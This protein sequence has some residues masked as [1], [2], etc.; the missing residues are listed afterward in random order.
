MKSFRRL[1]LIPAAIAAQLALAGLAIPAAR[2]ADFSEPALLVAAPELTGLYAHTVVLALPAGSGTHIG[3]I[4]NRPTET[5]LAA[6]F[7][8]SAP[9]RRVTSPI[10]VGG[11]ELLD[12]LFALVR[13]PRPPAEGSRKVLP[14]LFVAFQASDVAEAISR[15]PDRSRFFA[16]LVSWDRGELEAESGDGAW[17]LLDPDVELVLEASVDTLWSRLVA[18]TQSVTVQRQ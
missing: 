15:F 2:A 17:Y 8:D 14:G 7:P 16:G 12:N 18:R 6:L 11:P 5:S 1:L 4:L 10:F 3:F 13:S 9:A